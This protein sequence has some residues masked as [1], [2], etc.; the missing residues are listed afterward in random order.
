VLHRLGASPAVWVSADQQQHQQGFNT[1]WGM[2]ADRVGFL[3]AMHRCPAAVGRLK[4]LV[5]VDRQRDSSTRAVWPDGF[6]LRV[7]WLFGAALS[8]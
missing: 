3:G 4:H 6:M 5:T 1:P 7:A 8:G 2:A